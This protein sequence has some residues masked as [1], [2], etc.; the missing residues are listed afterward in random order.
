MAALAK[1]SN[2]CAR[3]ARRV[4]GKTVDVLMRWRGEAGPKA[5]A[6]RGYIRAPHSSGPGPG[7]SR[8]TRRWVESA[9]PSQRPTSSGERRRSRHSPPKHRNS[10]SSRRLDETA[11][12]VGALLIALLALVA[13]SRTAASPSESSSTDSAAAAA[14]SPSS[15]QLS[16]TH[17][18]PTVGADVEVTA[19]GLPPGKTVDLT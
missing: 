2:G 13:C 3:R 15:A 18:T 17:K 11:S 10:S 19:T 5:P 6:P 14:S 1:W 16:L 12:S 4:S 9:T 8:T 7:R